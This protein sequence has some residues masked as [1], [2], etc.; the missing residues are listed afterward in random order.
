[1]KKNKIILTII[2]L[3]LLVVL[4]VGFV[5][6]KIDSSLKP[7]IGIGLSPNPNDRS[8]STTQIVPATEC[9]EINFDPSLVTKYDI[10]SCSYTTIKHNDGY[11]YIV[12]VRHGPYSFSG[13]WLSDESEYIFTGNSIYPFYDRFRNLFDSK[14]TS[15]FGS[16]KARPGHF[17]V[18]AELLFKDSE[19]F[20]RYT[21]GSETEIVSGQL[22]ICSNGKVCGLNTIITNNKNA[23]TEKES[24]KLLKKELSKYIRNQSTR[25]IKLGRGSFIIEDRVWIHSFSLESTKVNTGLTR[26]CISTISLDGHIMMIGCG[27]KTYGPLTADNMSD[28]RWSIPDNVSIRMQPINEFVVWQR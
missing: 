17:T 7:S 23:I 18:D 24:R 11:A 14:M 9:D 5:V 2:I 3:S 25:E 8:D 21:V 12:S 10:F 27:N 19:P 13:V 15:I 22:D 4:V 16:Y 26:P 20:I 1:M 28:N 6:Y